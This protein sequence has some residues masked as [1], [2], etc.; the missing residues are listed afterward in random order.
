MCT[1]FQ[2]AGVD[3]GGRAVTPL[4]PYFDNRATQQAA[5][6]GTAGRKRYPPADRL[7]AA[8]QLPPAQLLAG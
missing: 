2:P 3:A 1:R 6:L 5:V 4:I 7:P 8:P